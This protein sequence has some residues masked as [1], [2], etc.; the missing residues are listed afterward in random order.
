[1]GGDHHHVTHRFAIVR[2]RQT[3]LFEETHTRLLG[4]APAVGGKVIPY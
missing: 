4:N 1:M 2:S 3:I